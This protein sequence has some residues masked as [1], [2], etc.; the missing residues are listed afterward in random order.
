MGKIL[1]FIQHQNGQVSR[2]SLEALKVAQELAAALSHSLAG[3]VFGLESPPEQLTGL[4]LDEVLLVPATEL[5]EYTQ[6]RFVA[7]MN[8]VITA[9]SPDPPLARQSYQA[10]DWPQFVH[11]AHWHRLGG[12][13]YHHLR[14]I[15][16]LSEIPATAQR[17]LKSAYVENT[18]KNVYLRSQLGKVLRE[19]KGDG[20]PVIPLQAAALLEQISG[21]VPIRALPALHL[22]VPAGKPAGALAPL[23]ESARVASSEPARAGGARGGGPRGPRLRSA[24]SAPTRSRCLRCGRHGG[25]VDQVVLDGAPPPRPVG[26]PPVAGG[27]PFSMG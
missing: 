9:E 11:N 25:P 21:T 13:T 16:L 8:A 20:I 10:L 4:K 19:L 27:S 24:R 22:S 2:N 5:E 17:Q 15:G 12:L 3:V 26:T 23:T 6:E 18:V 7:A 1:T 14:S